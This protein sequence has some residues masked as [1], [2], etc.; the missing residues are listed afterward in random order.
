MSLK[1]A[2]T[3]NLSGD[4]FELPLK[5]ARYGVGRRHD[6]DLRIKETYISGY[7]AE[8]V[9]S[10]DGT[11]LLSDLGSSNGTFLN[12][13]RIDGKEAIKNGDF[14]KFGILKVAVQ[15]D[16]TPS[17]KIVSLM[18]RPAFARKDESNTSA[19]A[20]EKTTGKVATLESISA[21]GETQPT[22][23]SAP[24]T[25]ELAE[26]KARLKTEKSNA[27]ELKDELGSQSMKTAM[28][29]KEIS[30]LRKDLATRAEE[31][32]ALNT[33]KEA[34]KAL[35]ADL[36]SLT[37]ELAAAK[38][39]SD[40]LAK[41]LKELEAESLNSKRSLNE[42]TDE[43]SSLTK[44]LKA[45][46]DRLA[47]TESNAQK[48][49]AGLAASV[50]AK[51]EIISRLGIENQA[52]NDAL[53]TKDGD[54]KATAKEAA[55]LA[56]LVA[57]IASLEKVA[58]ESRAQAEEEGK[59]RSELEKKLD[60]KSREFIS[61]EKELALL[62]GKV[63]NL[64]KAAEKDKSGLSDDLAAALAEKERI[65]TELKV[66]KGGFA[67]EKKSHES[68]TKEFEN[69]R[70]KLSKAIETLESKFSRQSEELSALKSSLQ[71]KENEVRLISAEATKGEMAAKSLTK[72]QEELESV[73][74]ALEATSLRE[75]EL[76][77]ESEKSQ[78]RL[79]ELE[80]RTQEYEAAV[81]GLEKALQAE[82]E[83]SDAGKAEALQA[84]SDLEIFRREI[85]EQSKKN[86]SELESSL[87]KL[88]S[89]LEARDTQIAEILGQLETAQKLI[90]G[91]E[92]DRSALRLEL[93]NLRK[94]GSSSASELS[95]LREKLSA[96]EAERSELLANQNLQSKDLQAAKAEA[97]E[98][99]LE[100]RKEKETSEGNIQGLEKT[101]QTKV[102][103]LETALASERVLAK[104]S[105]AG[106][107]ALEAELAVL[108]KDLDQLREEEEQ[109]KSR[110]AET[111]RN[112]GQL[113]A[114]LN[115][116]AAE[117]TRIAEE[118]EAAR[119]RASGLVS[120]T[121]ELKQS[122]S[123]REREMAER[124]QQHLRSESDIVQKLKRELGDALSTQKAA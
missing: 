26:L 97:N 90:G 2:V 54:L 38:R 99:R 41:E 95:E 15:E 17:P 74:A 31:L 107:K 10:T 36:K 64:S 76:A 23:T 77:A 27:S 42:K 104:D 116:E 1:L 13:R 115:R 30:T 84:K 24:A 100:L 81:A 82:K 21:K 62:Q 69:E 124:E 29:E 47:E 28:L 110:N 12:G 80:G 34:K 55:K 78:L 61:Q 93:E 88:T 65:N 7:H 46:K 11:Y 111:L 119:K 49:A 9:R 122:L 4:V 57:T 118:L 51:D 67:A 8:L 43:S 123:A 96:A 121:Q 83:L 85:G 60:Q 40:A 6:N 98:L 56:A 120:E 50:D 48:T 89:D 68:G 18:D 108:R 72:H 66:L 105:L 16:S 106:T 71:E 102:A 33:A 20:V 87:S 14:I 35:E 22:V 63:E 94:S 103:E 73:R 19:I 5:N 58:E 113:Q 92:V 59:K 109:L 79:T 86:I 70:S 32:K 75:R 112:N 101:L 3:T 39:A 53:S 44:E 91:I 114:E 117:R 37:G 52:L 45:L 25:T